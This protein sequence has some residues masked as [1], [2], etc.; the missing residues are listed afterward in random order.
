MKRISTRQAKL[1]WELRAAGVPLLEHPFQIYPVYVEKLASPFGTDL[2]PVNG[3]LAFVPRLQVYITEP[4]TLSECFVRGK[5][6]AAATW[7]LR[8]C[9]EHP[10]SYCFHDTERPEAKIKASWV[11]HAGYD[12]PFS[13]KIS[14]LA[15]WFLVGFIPWQGSPAEGTTIDLEFGVC[16]LFGEIHW[17]PLRL[18]YHRPESRGV[19]EI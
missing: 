12:F 6:I 17:F 13:A 15:R 10:D 4:I 2:I 9:V 18:T 1:L 8:R 11:C 14:L 3:G 19:G 7:K 5:D 16:D